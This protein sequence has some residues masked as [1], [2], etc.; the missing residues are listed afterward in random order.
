MHEQKLS[1]LPACAAVGL[2]ACTLAPRDADRK[3]SSGEICCDL[4]LTREGMTKQASAERNIEISRRPVTP[5]ELRLKYTSRDCGSQRQWLWEAVC[6][7]HPMAHTDGLPQQSSSVSAGSVRAGHTHASD[8]ASY[9]YLCTVCSLIARV[10]Q[11]YDMCAAA[12]F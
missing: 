4:K 3:R 9:L 5:C 11:A 8:V 12:G 1:E 7:S 6:V 2:P 10:V